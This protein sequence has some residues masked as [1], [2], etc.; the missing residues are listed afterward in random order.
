MTALGT[1]GHVI[2]TARRRCGL[3]VEQVAKATGI[4]AEVVARIE[5]ALSL[6]TDCAVNRLADVLDLDAEALRRLAR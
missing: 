4:P 1:L 6:P 3:S 5:A 2:T